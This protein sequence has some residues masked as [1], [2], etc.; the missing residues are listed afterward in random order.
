MKVSKL[1]IPIIVSAFSFAFAQSEP[2]HS[3][4]EIDCR[5]SLP[6]ADPEDLERTLMSATI[7]IKESLAPAM[8]STIG[9]ALYDYTNSKSEYDEPKQYTFVTPNIPV[10]AVGTQP[11][12]SPTYEDVKLYLYPADNSSESLVRPLLLKKLMAAQDK[13]QSLTAILNPNPMYDRSPEGGPVKVSMKV[14]S[15]F[16]V[17]DRDEEYASYEARTKVI[18]EHKG[19]IVEFDRCEIRRG[20]HYQSDEDDLVPAPYSKKSK[21]KQGQ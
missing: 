17:L 19:R 21:K 13:I 9:V 12:V 14:T 8:G 16:K 7:Q 20:E 18:I 10:Y 6:K 4:R 5:K 3:W 11:L 1:L 2:T 15:R